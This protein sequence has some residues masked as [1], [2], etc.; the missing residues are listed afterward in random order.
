ME[1]V[2]G[3]RIEVFPARFVFFHGADINDIFDGVFATAPKI[4]AYVPDADDLSDA[5]LGDRVE[6]HRAVEG[7]RTRSS[8]PARPSSPQRCVVV[9]LC[10]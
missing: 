4:L 10:V 8:P 9:K 5:L 2:P 1:L 6:A 3:S 7:G